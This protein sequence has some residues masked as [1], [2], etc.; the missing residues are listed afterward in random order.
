MRRAGC[1]AGK[2]HGT[3]QEN[4]AGEQSHPVQDAE[5]VSHHRPSHVAGRQNTKGGRRFDERE[6]DDAADPD[7]EGKEHEKSEDGHGGS[8]HGMRR[9][10]YGLPTRFASLSSGSYR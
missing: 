5:R 6:K 7:G 1:Q 3:T 10:E 9:K 4:D 2:Q 8:S